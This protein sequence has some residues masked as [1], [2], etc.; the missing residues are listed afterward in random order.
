MVRCRGD[1][2]LPQP[3]LLLP[4]FLSF[5]FLFFLPLRRPD[6][7]ILALGVELIRQ[8]SKRCAPFPGRRKIRAVR[9]LFHSF[10]LFLRF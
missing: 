2:R 7:F 6:R 10:F 4:F 1:L 8:L 5:S 3:V 9:F